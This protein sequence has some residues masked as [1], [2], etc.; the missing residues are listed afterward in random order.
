MATTPKPLPQT[1]PL[2]SLVGREVELAAAKA[3]PGQGEGKLVAIDLLDPNPYQHRARMDEDALEELVASIRANGQLE[4]VPVR[5]HPTNPGRFELIAGHRRCEAVRRLRDRAESD[6]DRLRF[7]QML[8]TVRRGV[9]ERQMR[10]WSV[11]ENAERADTSPVEQ[12]AALVDLQEKEGLTLEQLVA[13]T[14]METDRVKRLIRI[15]R[16]PDVIRD[17]CT[18]GVMV[19]LYDEK[20]VEQRTPK[21]RPKQE[22]R[23][24]DLLAALEFAAFHAH[25][26]RAG[27][28]TKKANE[29]VERAIMQALTDGWSYRRNPG[30]LQGTQGREGARGERR[31]HRPSRGS[32][33]PR[34]PLTRAGAPAVQ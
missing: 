27:L 3:A 16:A 31:R 9:T 2:R 26:M 5:V 17:G 6:E 7:S 32:E 11:V 8:A 1:N 28:S 21:G 23:H 20:G 25:L 12:G 19:Q 34:N 15:A 30:A 24:L 14:G 22:H 33:L 10:I 4:A 29:R 18:K 13:E